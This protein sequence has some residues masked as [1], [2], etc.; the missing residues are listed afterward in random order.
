MF[1]TWEEMSHNEKLHSEYYDFYKEVHGIRPRWIYAEG[2]E[3][4]YSEQQMESMLKQLAEDSVA[5]FAEEERL[6][7]E[8]IAKF[9]AQVAEVIESGAGDRETAI[10]WI[11]Q[12]Y[13][14]DGDWD[15]LCYQ[16]NLPYRYFKDLEVNELTQTQTSVIL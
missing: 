5:V 14:F 2:G 6:E 9:E 15:Y 11:S 7:Q 16:L 4:G 1:K 13:D 12:A 10:R 3:P 8:A